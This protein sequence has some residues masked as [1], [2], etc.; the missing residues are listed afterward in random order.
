M[1]ANLNKQ[2]TSR[3]KKT[4]LD[5]S[6]TANLL[7]VSSATVKNWVRC[8]YLEKAG[9]QSKYIFIKEDVENLRSDII[10]GKSVKLKKRANKGKALGTFI[11]DEYLQGKEDLCKLES[12][13]E[14]IKLHSIGL[15]TSLLLVI[16]NLLKKEKILSDIKIDDLIKK[17]D[18]PIKNK[19]IKKEIEGWIS[20]THIESLKAEHSFLME[21]DIPGQRDFPGILYQSIISEGEK[22]QSGSYYTPSRIVDGIIRDCVK[23]DSRVLDPCCGT[24]QFLL[25]FADV[26][27]NPSNIYGIDIDPVAVNIARIN[28]LVK[29]KNKDFTPNIYCKNTLFDLP[30]PSLEKFDVIATNPPWGFHYSKENR[31]KL[32]K[33]FPSV[34]SF[35]SY[36]YF[37][38]KSID[39]IGIDGKISFVLPESVLN[40]KT[41]RDIRKTILEKTK[42]EKIECFGRVFKNVFTPVIR[43]DLTKKPDG[44][45]GKSIVK[46]KNACYKVGQDRWSKNADYVFDIHTDEFDSKIIQKAY[47]QRHI[48]LEGNAQWALGI[49]TGDNERFLSESNKKGF[50][51]VYKGKDVFRFTLDAP[52]N[53]IQFTP[54]KFQ[55][56]APLEKYRAKE[57]LIY[58]FISKTP[59]FAYDDRQRLTLNSANILIPKISGYPIKAI[60]ALFNS[61]LYQF[62]FQ[63]KFSSIKVLRSH[64]E[65]LPLPIWNETVLCE[66]VRMVD[67]IIKENGSC[68]ELDNYIMDKFTLT[69][70]EKEHVKEFK[71]NH[72][73]L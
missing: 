9:G 54:D 43:L 68:E 73:K 52:S 50:E 51:P 14:F 44:G 67:G 13:I 22:S 11:P 31:E 65:Q 29:Y 34:S 19:V 25:A 45:K 66:I 5:V 18:L 3:N 7:G 60:A 28:L 12:I 10:S 69:Q 63:K 62:I 1:D 55:Q 26:V 36:S 8:G 35:E 71:E 20:N 27:E 37:L 2:K 38:A 59:V 23:K 24:G 41:H 61:S 56:V 53:F 49:V 64:I 32:R 21:C 57:K 48:T 17:K 58:R 33:I 4:I 6:D 30:N 72:G 42:I 16:L 47:N 40:V 46:K 15:P 70:E 39:L